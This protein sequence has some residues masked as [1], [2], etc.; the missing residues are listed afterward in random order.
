MARPPRNNTPIGDSSYDEQAL[1]GESTPFVAGTLYVDPR[2]MKHGFDYRWVAAKARSSD[3]DVDEAKLY[4]AHRTGWRP[5]TVG[6]VR[7]R[8]GGDYASVDYSAQYGQTK[9][10][11]AV[12][13]RAGNILMEIDSRK[14]SII[15]NEEH[16]KAAS[17]LAGVESYAG[18]A[19]P[20]GGKL[21]VNYQAGN[22]SERRT[23]LKF[24]D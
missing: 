21:G 5:V 22:V 20:S 15:R 10:D 17:A 14:K 9:S 4:D 1:G 23:G 19:A 2:I 6:D 8:L 24:S 16:R 7:E 3:P 12:Y 11:E 18:G 13:E